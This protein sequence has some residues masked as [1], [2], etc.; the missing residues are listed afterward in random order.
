LGNTGR[1]V[2]R[3]TR[4]NT[5][6]HYVPYRCALKFIGNLTSKTGLSTSLGASSDHLFGNRAFFSLSQRAIR[7]KRS[8]PRR[9]SA[10]ALRVYSKP[11]YLLLDCAAQRF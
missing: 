2:E 9:S 1:T 3:D 10:R 4:R 6:P 8:F 5:R 7:G 11:P